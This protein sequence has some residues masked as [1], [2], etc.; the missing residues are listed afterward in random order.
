MEDR[1]T[2][3]GDIIWLVGDLITLKKSDKKVACA[4][5]KKLGQCNTG[6]GQKRRHVQR[7]G[8]GNTKKEKILE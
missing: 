1:V 3:S 6:F 8:Q 4:E 7:D 2:R 5:G